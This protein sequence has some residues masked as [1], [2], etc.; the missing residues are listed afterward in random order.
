MTVQPPPRDWIAERAGDRT[1]SVAESATELSVLRLP[2]LWVHPRS[3]V[4][5]GQGISDNADK[6][7]NFDDDGFTH[8]DLSVGLPLTAGNV[9]VTPVLHLVIAGDD[10]VKI[11]SPTKTHDAK[12]WGGVSIGWSKDYGAAAQEAGSE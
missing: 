4:S 9:S 3:S 6:S 1:R 5:A 7:S 12:L 11:A 2:I 8:L 10:R